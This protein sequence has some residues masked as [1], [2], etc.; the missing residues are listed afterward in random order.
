M[1]TVTDNHFVERVRRLFGDSPCKLQVAA[2]PWR[3]T[4]AGLEIM[5][6]SSR[7][8]GRWVLPKGWAEK[9]ESLWDA[10]SRE[11]DEEAGLTG[12]IEHKEA[13]RYFYAKVMQIG[14]A[15]PCEVLVYPLKVQAV[16][17]KWKERG[18]RRR[19]WMSAEDAA[20]AVDEPDLAQVIR[21]F[22]G[23]ENLYANSVQF[24]R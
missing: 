14:P 9:H 12:E 16:A 13:G 22:G 10:A 20:A 3:R 23:C 21:D 17:E 11:A 4:G 6:I 15:V 8:T 2:L 5:L 18:L 7:D 1:G 24:G 19:Q